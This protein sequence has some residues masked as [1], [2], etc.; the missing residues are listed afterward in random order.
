[1]NN[2]C[3][4]TLQLQLRNPALVAFGKILIIHEGTPKVHI[5]SSNHDTEMMN[6]QR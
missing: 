1:M 3:V 4:H 5:I 6:P 2:V